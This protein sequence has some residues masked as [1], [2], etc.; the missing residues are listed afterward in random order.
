MLETQ[1]EESTIHPVLLRVA[2]TD[3]MF[4][5]VRLAKKLLGTE[6]LLQ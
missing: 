6:G 2:T 4:Y 3:R 5:S 1:T